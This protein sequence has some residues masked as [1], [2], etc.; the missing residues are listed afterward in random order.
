TPPANRE[1]VFKS[2]DYLVT[3]PVIVQSSQM[4]DIVTKH[5][6]EAASGSVRPAQALANMEAELTRTIDLS[7]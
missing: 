7:R 2:L 3:P 4:Q 1:A 6:K 5:L